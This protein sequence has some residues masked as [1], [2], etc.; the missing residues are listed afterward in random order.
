MAC[1]PMIFRILGQAVRR[2]WI[3]WLVGWVALAAGT[4]LA[5][6]AWNTLAQEESS[7][8]PADVPSRRAA[9]VFAQAFPTDKAASNVVLV[10]NRTNDEPGTF[11]RD[12]KFVETELETGLRQIAEAEG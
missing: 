10:L 6:P 3:V 11:E 1:R 9:E 12:L 4:W 8:L 2:S 7:F 5:A